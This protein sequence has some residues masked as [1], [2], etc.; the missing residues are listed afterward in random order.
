MRKN[1]DDAGRPEC[2]Q[3]FE[4][5]NRNDVHL[6]KRL[7]Q[8][9]RLKYAG[10]RVLGSSSV[11]EHNGHANSAF[12]DKLWTRQVW[13]LSHAFSAAIL[14]LT[15][16]TNLARPRAKVTRGSVHFTCPPPN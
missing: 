14:P 7:R 2:S 10:R 9:D 3:D 8:A 11:T 16:A 4:H 1:V 12:L 13:L 5:S 6:P 15:L